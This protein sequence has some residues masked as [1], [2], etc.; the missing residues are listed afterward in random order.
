[1]GSGGFAGATPE[2]RFRVVREELFPAVVGDVMDAM[3]LTSQFL[4][5]HIRPVRD[6]MVVLG[7]AMPVLETDIFSDEGGAGENPAL[8][9]PFG[10]MFRAL[11][12]LK[13]V[14]VYVCT[15][16]S[17]RYALWGGLMSTRA[18]VLGASGAV[19]DGYHRDTGDILDLGF[20]TF[21]S[22]AY[23]QYQGP[24]GRV[25]DFRVPVRIGDA[26]IR[27]GDILFGNVDGVCVVPKEAEVETF[28]RA[29]EKVR[30]EDL[31]A[32]A[33]RDG[34]STEEAFKRYGVM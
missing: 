26:S 32:R 11:D 6:D 24:R 34:V 19:L 1:M 18:Q 22:G 30:A 4:P 9:R 7:R 3:G 5:P 23:A 28:T 8:D 29:L 25:I 12:D 21:S 33:L 14:E 27:P 15:G 17:P 13:P 2:R 10:L 31:V 20:P 16:A